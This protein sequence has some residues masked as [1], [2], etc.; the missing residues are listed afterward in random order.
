MCVRPGYGVYGPGVGCAW[1]AVASCAHCGHRSRGERLRYLRQQDNLRSFSQPYI[2]NPEFKPEKIL[3]VSK[4]AYGLCSWVRAMEAYDRVVKVR[5]R[6]WDRVLCSGRWC[7]NEVPL[8]VRPK[9]A[10]AAV[11]PRAA[12]P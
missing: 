1:G 4:A 6:P 3:T 11:C 8:G 12:K 5:E 9:E 2:D 10:L 7:D